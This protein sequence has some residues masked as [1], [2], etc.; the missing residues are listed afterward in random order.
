MVGFD[1]VV[2]GAGIIGS[3][4]AWRL[5]QAGL[6]VALL[7]AG[8][9]GAEASWAGAGM[10]APGG[11]FEAG[12]PWAAFALENLRSYPDFVEELTAETGETIDF[13]QL[14]AI[15]VAFSEDD[16]RLIE[17]RASAQSMLGIT[18]FR[19]SPQ[20]IYEELPMAAGDAAG[21]WFYPEEGLVNPRDIMRALRTACIARGVVIREG[22]PVRA[23]R[24]KPKEAEI[25]TAEGA[26]SARWGVLAAGAWSSLIPVAGC[27]LPRAFPVRGHLTGL[28]LEPGSIGPILRYEQTYIVQRADGFTIAGAS[29][30]QCGFNR[31]VDPLIL[32]GIRERAARLAPRLANC[33]FAESWLGFRPGIESDG[34]VIGP[35]GGTALWLAYGHYRNGILMAPVTASRVAQAI[36]SSSEKDSSGPTGTR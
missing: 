28:H 9:M 21:G 4:I 10:L 2:V 36:T 32:A 18:I 8:R 25:I 27:S 19:M 22:V 16:W 20:E 30:E 11:E 24:P 34:P 17:A 5:A 3:S 7:D 29:S 26:I 31:A 15:E 35:A 14:G 33:D 1:A 13:Q 6:R 12:S 23:I